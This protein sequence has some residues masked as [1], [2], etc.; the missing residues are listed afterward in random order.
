MV[1]NR[2]TAARLALAVGSLQGPKIVCATRVDGSS[3]VV[4][5]TVDKALVSLTG[6][7]PRL[8]NWTDACH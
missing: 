1:T 6:E 7:L 2:C 4:A 3:V 8:F 5:V